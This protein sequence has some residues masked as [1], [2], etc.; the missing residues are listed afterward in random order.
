MWRAD[1]WWHLL[2]QTAPALGARVLAVTLLPLALEEKAPLP[3]PMPP[4][5]STR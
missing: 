5:K 4:P 1:E 2:N 3:G